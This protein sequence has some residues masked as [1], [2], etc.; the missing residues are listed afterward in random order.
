MVG[1]ITAHYGVQLDVKVPTAARQCGVVG[2]C[3][4]DVHQRE[5]RPQE[6]LRLEQGCR[7]PCTTGRLVWALGAYVEKKGRESSTSYRIG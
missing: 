3:E 2:R 6:A 4:I 1:R 5:D 7:L